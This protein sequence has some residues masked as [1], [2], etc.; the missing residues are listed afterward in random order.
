MFT[1]PCFY[2]I[3]PC[4]V[5]PPL[6]WAQFAIWLLL[7]LHALVS[8]SWLA[9]WAAAAVS[10]AA[11]LTVP[12]SLGPLLFLATCLQLALAIAWREEADLLS[13]A[14]FLL[15]SAF[16]YLLAIFGLSMVHAKELWIV[17]YPV[18]FTLGT[19][20]IFQR[21]PFQRG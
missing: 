3:I 4:P 10:L 6:L 20:I 7:T 13:G 12:F 8:R 11:C 16:L 1:N 15:A 14:L 9:L 5:I 17:A 2:A 19:L 21:S 18:V